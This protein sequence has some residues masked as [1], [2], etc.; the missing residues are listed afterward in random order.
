MKT[1]GIKSWFRGVIALP[2]LLAILI[3]QTIEVA[4]LHV[5][6]RINLD[7][8]VRVMDKPGPW[9]SRAA[10][11]DCA[12]AKPEPPMSGLDH[13]VAFLTELEACNEDTVAAIR[14]LLERIKVG[15]EVVGLMHGRHDYAVA[16][17]TKDENLQRIA[18]VLFAI[19]DRSKAA[20]ID[21][22]RNNPSCWMPGE[23][24]ES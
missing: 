7:A 8:F 13:T 10:T 16:I 9:S 14:Q 19:P 21:L 4:L 17:P 5:L 2:I 18:N 22:V 20:V 12:A 3:V 6:S 1:T 24:Q 15:K 11:L 23:S